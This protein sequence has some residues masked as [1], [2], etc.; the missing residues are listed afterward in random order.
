[1]SPLRGSPE[2]TTAVDLLEGGPLL[3]VG[4]T[5]ALLQA[6]QAIVCMCTISAVQCTSW[7]SSTHR[8]VVLAT[9]AGLHH[10]LP[11]LCMCVQCCRHVLRLSRRPS[12]DWWFCDNFSVWL[13]RSCLELLPGP[14][15]V[16]MCLAQCHRIRP[17]HSTSCWYVHSH[18]SQP[19]QQKH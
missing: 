18:G 6:A 15:V 4:P 9:C 13:L 2:R 7:V 10:Q 14:C 5:H 11:V 17:P 8:R 12:L 19:K 1:M 16:Q 3:S